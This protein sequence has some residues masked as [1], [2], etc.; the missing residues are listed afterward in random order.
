MSRTG[1]TKPSKLQI[2]GIPCAVIA[3]LL[4]MW[5]LAVDLGLVPSFL[6][7]SPVQVM[8]ALVD[9][10]SLLASHSATTLAESALGLLFGVLLGFITAVLMERFVTVD[11]ALSPL[12]TVS[13]TI[14][15]VAIAP[16]LVLWFGYDLLPKVLLITLT[17]YF[18]ITVSFAQGLRSVD[19]DMIDL[20]RTMNASEW[21][22]FWEVKFPAALP[23]F[24]SGLRI[25]AT[26]AIVGAVIAEWLG[27]FAGLGVY[28]TRVRK[29]FSYEIGRAHV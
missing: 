13:Q 7:P 24:F 11:L 12:V 6:I 28:M 18:P 23:Q 10:I 19:P 16:L 8:Q 14:P 22:I 2:I 26:Y 29:S 25:S 20:M 27:G 9:D 1:N 4:I 3:G 15:T 5:E 21:S 17:T